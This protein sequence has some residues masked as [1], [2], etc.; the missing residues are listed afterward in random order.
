MR[1][2]Q[3]P[4][5]WFL[6]G[7]DPPLSICLKTGCNEWKRACLLLGEPECPDSP[8]Y[9]LAA[10]IPLLQ[11]LCPQAALGLLCRDQV[12]Q[13]GSSMNAK[14]PCPQES[15]AFLPP[16][17]PSLELAVLLEPAPGLRGDP[18]LGLSRWEGLCHSAHSPHP[19]LLWSCANVLHYWCNRQ[20]L[21]GSGG[22]ATLPRTANMEG[23]AGGGGG[24]GQ[25]RWW[26]RGKSTARL[27]SPPP[28]C[29]L[30]CGGRAILACLGEAAHQPPPCPR[31]ISG[32]AAPP[33]AAGGRRPPPQRAEGVGREAA[34]WGWSAFL[35][36]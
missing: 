36:P 18:W 3:F 16:S 22:R 32:G 14:H 9:A 28:P 25:P 1:P 13:L 10:R 27:P 8:G 35:Q 15:R 19:L 21:P 26:W 11:S 5:A 23:T 31:P 29:R 4:M 20:T 34:E 12:W 17:S 6:T 24:P 2:P 33:L 7:Q 30:S